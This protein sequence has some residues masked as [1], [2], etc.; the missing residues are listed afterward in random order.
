[1]S[2]KISNRLGKVHSFYVDDAVAHGEVA[3]V[4]LYNFRFWLDHNK[5]NS[6]NAKDGYFWTYNS[7]RAFSELFPYL[8]PKKIQRTIRELEKKNLLISTQY[9]LD[10]KD[11]TKWY[12]MPGY[13]TTKK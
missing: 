5:A 2:S 3:A 7:A 9:Y 13:E 8:H 12:T 11:Q 4:L 1:M 6:K 10:G